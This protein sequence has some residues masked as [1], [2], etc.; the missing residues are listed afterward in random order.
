M[1]RPTSKRTDVLPDIVAY[2]PHMS[3]IKPLHPNIKTVA[4]LIAN[5]AIL[6]LSLFC[7][8]RTFF[9]LKV[10]ITSAFKSQILQS[11]LTIFWFPTTILAIQTSLSPRTWISTAMLSAWTLLLLLAGIDLPLPLFSL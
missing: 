5:Q 10:S 6:S 4:M 2:D 3:C 8:P 9:L 1:S 7:P 11:I